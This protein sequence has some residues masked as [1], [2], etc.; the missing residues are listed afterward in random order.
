M[1]PRD[2]GARDAYEAYFADIKNIPVLDRDEQRDLFERYHAGDEKAGDRLTKANLRLV[3]KIAG[4]YRRYRVPFLDLIQE[5]NIGLLHAK[6]KYDPR[7]G[8]KF[9][10]YAAYWI[11]AYMLRY[12]LQSWSLVKLGTTQTQ[13]LIFFRLPAVQRALANGTGDGNDPAAIAAAIGVK[14]RD[15]EQMLVRLGGDVSLDAPAKDDGRPATHVELLADESE[16]ADVIIE[17]R[18]ASANAFED[19]RSAL[20]TLDSR[21][22]F[23][24]ENRAMTDEPMTLADIGRH[25]GCSRERV[26]QLQT[27][28]Y[29]K[30]RKH[31]ADRRDS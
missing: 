17:R 3:A 22:R 1:S 12:V 8:T 9:S 10:T 21:E 18:E 25:L 11:R 27:R 26:R 15:V 7:H 14:L 23:I 16:P 20:K 13:R 24:V 4:E 5:G 30:M 2:V 6:R 28:A 19:A 31:L 29:A